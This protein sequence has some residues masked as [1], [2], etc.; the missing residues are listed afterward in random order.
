MSKFKKEY[1]VI[2]VGGGVNGLAAGAYLQKAGLDVAVFERRDELGTHCNTEELGIPG[3]RY[4]MHACGIMTLGSPA[5]ND[6]E[7]ERFGLEMLT[8]SEWGYFNPFKDGSAVLFHL[9]DANPQYE[10][11]KRIN[12]H[13][14]EVFRRLSHYMGPHWVNL[15]HKVFY[16][17]PS[18]ENME[19]MMA[20]M[21]KCPVVPSGWENMNGFE[22]A[23]ALF[24]DERIKTSVLN[25]VVA[26]DV[27]PWD[28]L[29]GP[30]T[31]LLLGC[32]TLS[33]GW[34]YTARGGS[35]AL[36]HALAR[37]F[38]HYGGAVMQACPVEKIIIENGEAKGVVLSKHAVYP[39]AEIRAKRAVI[40][41]LTPGPTFLDL[42]GEAHLTPEV[43]SAVTGYDY[44]ISIFMVH[45][46]LN[47]PPAWIQAA[48]F[49]EVEKAMVFNL[50]E[51]TDDLRRIGEGHKTGTIPDPPVPSA[52][53]F[54]GFAMADPTQAPDG[55]HTLHFWPNFPADPKN[56]GGFEN[57][58]A[59]REK[60][61]DK[62]EDMASEY[63][64]NLKRATVSRLSYSP[65]DIYRRNA[66]AVL[67]CWGG[68]ALSP[69]QFYLNRP[70]PGC[71][72]PRTPISKLYIS[73]S[74]GAGPGAT[75][76]N[77]GVIAA[78]VA[79]EDLGVRNQDWWKTKALEPYQAYCKKTW[80]KKWNPVVD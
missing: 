1:D 64:T 72:A 57:W 32:F 53:C 42:V 61:A 9:F 28:R 38:M 40:S 65:L 52:G 29:T 35:H 50:V 66:S 21:K 19:F 36:P 16:A 5:Y 25:V 75:S 79:G 71:G 30:I 74:V 24:E 6:L 69:E 27:W 15:V 2:V 63:I 3:V 54:Q 49:P 47:E 18:V 12:K 22:F 44:G 31:V 58:D 39:E 62:V 43:V 33:F 17:M 14:A 51:S 20:F 8:S 80:G 70:F 41:N 76:L 73:Q 55:L 60:Y 10:S 34:C 68:G 26:L 45:Y 46:V 7:L 11:W 13:D 78:T 37:C 4:N 77:P 23:D 59:I 56:E 48:K 67:G